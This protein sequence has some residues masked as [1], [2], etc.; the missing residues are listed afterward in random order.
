MDTS[1]DT[2]PVVPVSKPGGE[3][4]V[5]H[6]SNTGRQRSPNY[7]STHSF[8]QCIL[9]SS[10]CSHVFV[11][12]TWPIYF[13]SFTHSFRSFISFIHFFHSFYSF[14][15]FYSFITFNSFIH[16]IHSFISFIFS[17]ISFIFH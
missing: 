15:S 4:T 12:F 11:P 10:S 1:M 17:F 16:S 9:H 7:H 3:P 2:E 5:S 6:L 13:I 14:Y 8:Y